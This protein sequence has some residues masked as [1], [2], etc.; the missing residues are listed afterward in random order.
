M[1]ASDHSHDA[2][3]PAAEPGADL[4]PEREW[5]EF[6]LAD[7]EAAKRIVIL[8]TGIFVVGIVLYSIVVATL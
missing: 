8:M 7:K 2:A 3:H 1:I 6:R 4:F 5:H